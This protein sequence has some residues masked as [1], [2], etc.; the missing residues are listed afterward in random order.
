MTNTRGFVTNIML[1]Q[2]V[3]HHSLTMPYVAGYLVD[4]PKQTKIFSMSKAGLTHLY[5]FK[6]ARVNKEEIRDMSF[7]SSAML[8]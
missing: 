2:L 8:H 7:V 1:D 6:M 5:T 4:I 3:R